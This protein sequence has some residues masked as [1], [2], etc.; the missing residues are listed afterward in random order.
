MIQVSRVMMHAVVAVVVLQMNCKESVVAPLKGIV[1]FLGFQDKF[2]L[3]MVLS[4][5][6]LY[7]CAGSDGVW[8]RDIRRMNQWQ[9]LGLRDTSLGK[10]TNVGAL[11]MDVF[12]EDILVAYNGSASHVP[13]ES[14]VAVWRSTNS[15]ITW[16]RSDRGIPESIT[17]PFEPNTLSSLQRSPHNTQ[18]VLGKVGAAIYRSSDSGHT[19]M[20]VDGRR[21]AAVNLDYVRW[22]PFR[23]GEVWFYGETSVFAPYMFRLTDYGETFGGSV[24]FNALG[25]PSD[26]AVNNVAFDAGTPDIVYAATSYGIIKTTDGGYTWRANAL[27]LLGNG[28]VFCMAHHPSIGGLLYLAG[29]RRVYVT[30]DRGTSIHLIGEIERGFIT[31]LVLDTQGNQLFVGTTEGGIYALKLA[32]GE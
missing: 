31:S 2:A 11:D 20:L 9:Y 14:T 27:R 32:V 7:V 18:I 1:E 22:N 30:R 13:A 17:Y 10:Y 25:F 8:R 6:Y 12:G 19:W 23:S 28:F 26:G 15:G 3:R 29:G 5:P 24:N 16:S 21:G 4:E